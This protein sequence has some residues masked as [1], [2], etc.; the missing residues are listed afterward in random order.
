[1]Y[2][3]IIY[4]YILV[5]EGTL[6]WI[7]SL[8]KDKCCSSIFRLFSLDGVWPWTTSKDRLIFI[9]PHLESFWISKH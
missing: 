2:N 5:H 6:D 9:D 8:L 3:S 7:T 4:V 1:M